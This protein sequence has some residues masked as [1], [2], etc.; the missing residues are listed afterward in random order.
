MIFDAFDRIRIVNLPHRRDR[1][2]QME[3][4]LRRIGL[5]GDPRVAFFAA[6][7][8]A[9]AGDFTSIGAHGVYLSQKQILAEAAAAGES[10]LILEDDCDFAP[11]ARHYATAEP[12]DI[13]YGGYEASDPADLA[14]SDIIGAHMMGFTA[15]GAKAVS[16]YLHDLRYTG[17]HPPIDG[18][19]VWFRRAHP[20]VATH[21]AVPPLGH[22]RSS[23]TDIA[24]LAFYDR[25]PVLR[26]LANAAR[27]VKRGL[28]RRAR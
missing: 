13:F 5:W 7:R 28:T 11:H 15:A 10:V 24:D 22:Q 21:F 14:R 17:I 23:R 8:P 9:D 3:G 6:I 26:W 19:Y 12:W 27:R 18:A 16:A 1:A 25:W 2:A 20:E 4:E